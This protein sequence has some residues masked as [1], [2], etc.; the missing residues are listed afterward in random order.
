A[1]VGIRGSKKPAQ[2]Q[3]DNPFLAVAEEQGWK[4]PLDVEQAL[5]SMTYPGNVH[6]V[7]IRVAASLAKAGV[8]REET[9]AL[10][11]EATQR[12]PGVDVAKW[13]WKAEEKAIGAAYDSA[14][15]KFDIR[16]GNAPGNVV[17]R[18]TPKTPD[19]VAVK[20]A[21]I[22]AENVVQFAQKDRAKQRK[23][24]QK[25]ELQAAFLV[26]D[27]LIET[28]RQDG[29]DIMLA[30]GGIWIYQEG[31]W[32]TM[33]P[34]DEQR[35]RTVV[36]QGFEDLGEAAKGN[37]LTLAWKRLTEHPRLYKDKVPWSAGGLIVCRNG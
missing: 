6:D 15:A 28:L 18:E 34:A 17:S 5:A 21:G 2:T 14:V 26:A 12:A 22:G 4:P 11:L 16:P 19:S 36:Q 23:S 25:A 32:R 3:P 29:Q 31:F 33:S 27:G 8:S 24:V 10:I 35:L 9:V 30:E 7:Q 37:T 20:G 13:D 1:K